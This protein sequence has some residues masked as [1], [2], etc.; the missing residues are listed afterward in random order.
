M[1]MTINRVALVTGASR[2]IGKSV[3]LELARK[4]FN[5]VLCSRNSTQLQETQFLIQTQYPEL[6][7]DAFP[8]DLSTDSGC[9]SLVNFYRNLYQELTILVNNAGV[10]LPGTLM[11][12]DNDQMQLQ[13]DLN[14]FSAYR[15]TKGLWDLLK[16][17][18]RAHVFNMCSIAS[19]T[20]YAAGGG[21]S[22][23]KFALLGF[24][25]SL[26]LEGIPHEVAV[27]SVLPGATLTD[28][29]AG[30]DLPESRFM[31]SEDV[32]SVIGNAF[33]INERTVMEEIV[34]RPVLGDI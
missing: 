3:A 22:V 13:M 32:A 6:K 31:R 2:G 21:Y 20:A 15:I 19:I 17:T 33:D 5:L 26:R 30:V 14:F 27:S 16:V 24:S 1:K 7:V 4:G 10:F 34:I 28:S 9:K 8:A 25:K 11:E 12:E 29:W 18:P 23:S